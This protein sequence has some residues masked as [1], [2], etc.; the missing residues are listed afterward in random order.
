M[1]LSRRQWLKVSM[2]VCATSGVT[3]SLAEQWVWRERAMLGF[4]T[5]VWIRAGH[6]HASQLEEA[7]DAAVHALRQVEND[8]SLFKPDS[9]VA[10]LNATGVLHHPSAHMRS[11]LTWSA[12][13]ARHS[14]GAFDISMQPLWQVWSESH[15]QQRLP[16]SVA[17][18]R[19]QQ[20]VQWRAVELSPDS[21]RLNRRGMGVSLNGIAQGY[22]ADIVKDVL[23]SRGISH[24]Q[25]DTGE[26]AL[27]G[28]GPG[29]QPWTFGVQDVA[30]HPHLAHAPVLQADGR[31]MA[32]SSDAH[33][34]FSA[35]HQNH[36]ILNPRTGYSPTH[37]SSVTV[38]APCCVLAD[39]LTKVFFMQ[40]PSQ[41]HATAKAWGV[42]VLAQRKNGEWVATAGVPL[43]KT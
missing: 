34:V 4:G 37:W 27:L 1:N 14:G 15:A 43:L 30:L 29:G 6:H 38:L 11:V 42:D 5:T 8:M 23:Q 21:V 24:A 31:A 13:V 41:L 26:T 33:T 35:D 16:T 19:A 25:I 22:A 2:G 20:L 28:Q 36:H 40:A 18:Q 7:L 39:A 32:T 17:L 9:A 10:Q 3:Q 12:L